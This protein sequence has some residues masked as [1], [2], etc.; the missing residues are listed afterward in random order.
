MKVS[1]KNAD[2]EISE[3]SAV[4]RFLLESCDLLVIILSTIRKVIV[5]PLFVQL[6]K[7]HQSLPF[8]A[9]GLSVEPTALHNLLL[10]K[11]TDFILPPFDESRVIPRV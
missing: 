1:L 3:Y 10:L 2:R 9:M 4:P 7:N 11:L 8:V 5:K 6:R